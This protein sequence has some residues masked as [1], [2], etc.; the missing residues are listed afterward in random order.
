MILISASTS[1]FVEDFIVPEE[2]LVEY[3]KNQ[4][5]FE[6]LSDHIKLALSFI[7]L[8]TFIGAYIV[9]HISRKNIRFD[10]DI[11]RGRILRLF[12]P[13]GKKYYIARP[14]SFFHLLDLLI[15]PIYDRNHDS[16]G[17]VVEDED[18][19]RISIIRKITIAIL[20]ICVIY[21]F[22]LILSAFKT[23]LDPINMLLNPQSIPIRIRTMIHEIKIA[24]RG[25]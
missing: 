13:S 2:L 8:G 9:Y 19:R 5:L 3:E 23:D 7:V 11:K 25:G 20:T 16:T 10:Y 6:H 24:L 15:L 18:L 4:Y 21:G 17:K 14:K 1:D 22:L 12:H